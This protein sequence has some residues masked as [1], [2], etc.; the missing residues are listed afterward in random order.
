VVS[1]ISSTLV[2]V[3]KMLNRV[4]IVEIPSMTLIKT[5]DHEFKWFYCCRVVRDHIFLVC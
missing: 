1:K 3:E 4:D 5:I 2:A